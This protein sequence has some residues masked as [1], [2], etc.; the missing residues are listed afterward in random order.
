MTFLEQKAWSQE[1]QKALY[2]VKDF[3]SLSKSFL[4]YQ[5][6]AS[7]TIPSSDA[8]NATDD[9]YSR[10]LV[11]SLFTASGVTIN[12]EGLIIG[13]TYIKL[14]ENHTWSF[15][16]RQAKTNE[17]MAGLSHR[18]KEKVLYG[19]LSNANVTNYSVVT[20][21]VTG[22]TAPSHATTGT[23]KKLTFSN[24]LAAKTML[25]KQNVPSTG[26]V[27][28]LPT[29]MI[30]DILGLSQF[31]ESEKIVNAVIEEGF[32]GRI[33]G[34][35]VIE[36]NIEKSY[37]SLPTGSTT[38]TVSAF[39][40]TGLTDSY[41]AYAYHPDF[42]AKVVGNTETFVSLNDPLYTGDVTTITQRIG[43]GLVRSDKKGL[44]V[45]AQARA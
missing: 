33:A 6:M 15:D 36:A 20:D 37:V 39:S 24:I 3:T 12:M 11:P 45:I 27:L 2:E 35:D 34:F 16:A 25:N 43:S 1:I 28:L 26:R 44:V 19:W 4:Q 38:I 31:I 14:D 30:P 18:A 7:F 8:I 29:D 23:R 40:T 41:A 42:V 9:N 17:L 21:G 10:P 5:D 32:V 13:P 22:S